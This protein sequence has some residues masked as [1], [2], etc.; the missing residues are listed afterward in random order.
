[1]RALDGTQ[2]QQNVILTNAIGVFNGGAQ[3]GMKVSMK[4]TITKRMQEDSMN[5]NLWRS[6][7]E[8]SI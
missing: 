4:F 8:K 7:N 3:K 5:S 1:M 6:F 2:T